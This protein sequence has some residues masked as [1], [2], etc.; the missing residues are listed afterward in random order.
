MKTFKNIIFILCVCSICSKAV[1]HTWRH[2]YPTAV[3]VT[4]P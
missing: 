4:G 3:A 2:F 1:M